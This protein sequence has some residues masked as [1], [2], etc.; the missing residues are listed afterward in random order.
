VAA[1]H[2]KNDIKSEMVSFFDHTAN[3]ILNKNPV[4]SGDLDRTQVWRI[5]HMP[6]AETRRIEPDIGI[7]LQF[8]QMP[9]DAFG[10]WRAA[11]IAGAN[12]KN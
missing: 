8:S 6:V 12:K 7:P 5:A 10:Q 11:D 3:L 2:A 1:I 9:E 4:P